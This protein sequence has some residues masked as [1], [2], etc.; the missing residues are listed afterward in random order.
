MKYTGENDAQ[1]SGKATL[2]SAIEELDPVIRRLSICS[3]QLQK[4]SDHI[5]GVRPQEVKRGV[6]DP[7]AP[8]H[9]II[10]ALHQKRSMLIKIC[11]DIE[12]TISAIEGSL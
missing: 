7:A 11:D 12:H 4:L 9:S 2:T 8:P 10:T 1:Q 3:E 5:D 6:N